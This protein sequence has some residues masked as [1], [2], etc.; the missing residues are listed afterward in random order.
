MNQATPSKSVRKPL[1]SPAQVREARSIA[2]QTMHGVI[3]V[4]QDQSGLDAKSF[5]VALG[6]MFHYPVYA[7]D[8]LSQLV[9]A[10]QML[11]FSEAVE[12]NCIVFG[13]GSED[14]IVILSDPFDADLQTWLEQRIPTAFACGLAHRSDISAF[15][16]NHEESLHAMD[17]IQEVAD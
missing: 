2:A 9:P 17:S 8:E 6:S 14:F 5:V 15:L 13:S 1:F 12:R 10:F 4:L 7:M 11:T 16:S 3:E